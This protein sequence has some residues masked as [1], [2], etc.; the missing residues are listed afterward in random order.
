MINTTKGLFDDLQRMMYGFGD[1][2]VPY[3]NSVELVEQF[4]LGFLDTFLKQA[5]Q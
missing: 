2:E 1:S 3:I 5:M 4:A